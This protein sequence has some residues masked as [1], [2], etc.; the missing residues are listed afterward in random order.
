MNDTAKIGAAGVLLLVSSVLLLWSSIE[1][2]G[3]MT[4]LAAAGAAT[5]GLAIGSLL[6]G[7]TGADGRVV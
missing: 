5:T 1:P 6:M 4:L 7:S 2:D 3:T